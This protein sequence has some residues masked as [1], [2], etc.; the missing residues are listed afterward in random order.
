MIEVTKRRFE[1][2]PDIEAQKESDIM[3][4]EKIRMTQD[5]LENTY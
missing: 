4:M 5:V 2:Q 1:F 3:P